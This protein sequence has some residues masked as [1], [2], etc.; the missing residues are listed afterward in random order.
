MAF[1][2]DTFTVALLVERPD[3]PELS[4]TEAAAL[5]DAHMS[6][7]A[8]LHEAGHLLAVGPVAGGEEVRGL[9]LLNVSPDRVLELKQADPAVRAGVYEVR[10]MTWR[11]PAGLV[12][13]KPGRVPRSVAGVS[14]PA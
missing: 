9:S 14:G 2:F 6:H 13:F 11:V 1:A 12:S 5:Q 3:G 8:D 4:E 10:V 7:L